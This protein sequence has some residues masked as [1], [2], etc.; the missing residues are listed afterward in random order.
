M[1][2]RCDCAIIGGGPAGLAAAIALRK[3]GV[4][5]VVLIERND[6]LGGILNQCIHVGF[7]LTYFGENYTGPEY[8]RALS[9]SFERSGAERLLGAMVLEVTRSRIVKAMSRTEGYL[10]I[11]AGAVVVATG[12][13]ERTRDNLEIPGT[14][15]AGVFTAG[16]AQDLVNRRGYRLGDKIVIQGS[17]DIGLIMARRLSIEG[18]EVAGV[19][20]RLPYLAGL[21]R[22]KVQCL[23][24]FGIP[25][26]LRSQVCEITGTRRV[27][28]VWVERLDEGFRPIPGT[29]EFNA[30]DTVLF[31]VGLIPEV[32]ILRNS[33]ILPER[34]GSIAVNSSFEVEGTGIFL[35]GNSCHIHDLA[36]N[37][38]REGEEVALKVEAFLRRPAEYRAA[39][40]EAL[41]YS[42]LE[43]NASY[44][45]AFFERL[46]RD[47]S[48]V[49][50]VC[51]KGCVV[52]AEGATCKRGAEYF[53][54][55]RKGR[56]Q[57]LTTSIPISADGRRVRLPLR[58][59]EA[60]DVK[61]IP[62]IKEGL[63]RGAMAGAESQSIRI[64]GKDIP[65][66]VERGLA[67][68]VTERK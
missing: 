22:N 20:E 42:P 41:P 13:R 39:T 6:S 9:E 68:A 2:N 60:V 16:Q 34:G 46:R 57:I 54:E 21:A 58:S 56:R 62:R 35:A 27:E 3:A 4:E 66:S 47:D 19:F 55:S 18:C 51:P 48:E 31:S 43:A 45:D 17:G 63:A 5:D 53:R 59:L 12:C 10:E 36:D 32:D 37:A 67:D 49:C 23:D 7:G 30:C 15:P 14:R 50:I 29:R 8:A 61:D 25:L 44:D 26:R 64:D 24:H 11:E 1:K 33:G 52:S 40:T 65:F 28:G 38:S